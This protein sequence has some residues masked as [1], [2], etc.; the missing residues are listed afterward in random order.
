MRISGNKTLQDRVDHDVFAS[1]IFETLK[2]TFSSPQEFHD[3]IV[4]KIVPIQG[5]IT[6]D[7]LGISDDDLKMIQEDTR[8]V[9][10]SAASVSFDDPL[11]NALEVYVHHDTRVRCAIG[12]RTQSFTNLTP[13]H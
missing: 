4:K 13:F 8:I 12:F 7:R 1:R 2:A 10:N 5:D 11:G 9:I 6:I 3:T